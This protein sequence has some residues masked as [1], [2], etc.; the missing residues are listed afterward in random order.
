M[1]A[2]VVAPW[3]T[4][5]LVLAAGVGVP[6]L[7]ALVPLIKT[8]RTTVRAAID[9]R[10][11]DRQGAGTTRFDAWLARLQ[12]LDRTLLMA[13]RNMLRRRARFLLAVGLLGSAGTLFVAGMS[14]MASVQAVPKR[15]MEQRRW[16]VDVQLAGTSQVPATTLT[17]LVAQLP[18]VSHV[19]AWT[20]MQTGI[21]QPGQIGVTRTYP[22]QA[23]GSMTVSVIPTGSSLVTVPRLLEG[24]WLHPGES[25]AVVISQAVRA[26]VLPGLRSGD[27]IE[28]SI[29]GRPTRWRVAGIS[30]FLFG[31]PSAYVTAAGF[32]GAAGGNQ[33]NSLRIVTDAQDEATRTAV[34]NAAERALTAASIPVLSSAS[35]DRFEAAGTGHMLPIVAI[36]LVIAIGM[37]MVGWVGLASTMST[38]VLERTREFGVMR[39][40]GASPAAVGRLVVSEGIFIALASCLVAAIPSIL[41]AAAMSAALGKLFLYSALPIRMSTGAIVVW[42][43]VVV[44]GAALATA[45]PAIRA[46]RLSV[47]EALAY[48]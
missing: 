23:H 9:H 16:D 41:L 27:T 43:V 8:C 34:A 19:E 18:H 44:L 22:D 26:E 10:G 5:A 39:A 15:A 38:N 7:F 13:Q 3:W 1:V 4:Y 20:V 45:A 24:R 25:G 17:S 2:S 37:A 6:L 36:F 28:L 32:A 14:T 31:S 48:L 12:G 29:G 40:I 35:A 30:E 42:M 46:S 11:V 47:R 21:A 33:S